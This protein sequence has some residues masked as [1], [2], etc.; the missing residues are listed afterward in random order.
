VHCR[1]ATKDNITSIYGGSPASRIADPIDA[2]H[3][4]EWLLQETFDA[5]GN[6]IRYEYAKDN[7][8][9]DT[10]QDPSVDL[11][12]ISDLSPVLIAS[13]AVTL[14]AGAGGAP[15]PAHLATG[16]FSAV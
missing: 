6:H 13:T 9:L 5:T 16:E 8:E 15:D 3:V 14:L 2:N 1:A 4:Y 12:A 11:S 10:H 7:P